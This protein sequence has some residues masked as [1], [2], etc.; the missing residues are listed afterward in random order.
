MSVK[1]LRIYCKFCSLYH[2]LVSTSF[3][4]KLLWC[5]CF[6]LRLRLWVLFVETF[7]SCL[8]SM[9]RGSVLCLFDIIACKMSLT[10]YYAASYYFFSLSGSI[11]DEL[12][13]D[14]FTFMSWLRLLCARLTITLSHYSW[15]PVKGV[16]LIIICESFTHKD[17][18]FYLRKMHCDM[19]SL[20]CY[21]YVTSWILRLRL[22]VILCIFDWYFI[23][24][25]MHHISRLWDWCLLLYWSQV[26]SAFSAHYWQLMRYLYILSFVLLAFSPFYIH[27]W[28]RRK[29]LEDR[30]RY[31][32][33]T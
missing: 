20:I 19:H 31:T 12:D 26:K 2:V 14:N 25:L 18:G 30:L 21:L 10:D 4:F 1:S 32:I 5:F 27:E 33:R 16:E 9:Q 11:F 6:N 7:Y 24:L 13:S 29:I 22:R 15:L 17:K 28:M 3:H 23:L 8:L